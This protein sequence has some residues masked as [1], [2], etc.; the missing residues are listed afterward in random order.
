MTIKK[1]TEY[2][3]VCLIGNQNKF[4]T[5]DINNH[6]STYMSSSNMTSK[7][8]FIKPSYIIKSIEKINIRRCNSF[9][10]INGVVFTYSGPFII[11]CI[12]IK[13]LKEDNSYNIKDLI[14]FYNLDYSISY[15]PLFAK[16]KRSYKFSGIVG[17][18]CWV[19]IKQEDLLLMF[20]SIYSPTMLDYVPDTQKTISSEFMKEYK[21]KFS[22]KNTIEE[23]EFNPLTEIA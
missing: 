23:V 8:L 13:K 2:I 1:T 9:F 22:N 11:P 20:C 5:I 16:L 6:N 10:N 4:I 15:K 18:K 7:N 14:L 17:R 21:E 12:P 3:P 19:P